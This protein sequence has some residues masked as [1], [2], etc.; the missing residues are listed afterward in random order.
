MGLPLRKINKP[1]AVSADN[2]RKRHRGHP[3]P[4]F[5]YFYQN[6]STQPHGYFD[7]PFF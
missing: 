6:L 5:A 7:L 2:N 4:V 1:S 3:P